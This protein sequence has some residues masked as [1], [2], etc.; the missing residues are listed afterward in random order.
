MEA[1]AAQ[2]IGKAAA[3]GASV[4][5]DCAPDGAGNAD[6]PGETFVAEA[7]HLAGKGG[8][9]RAAFDAVRESADGFGARA[10][11]EHESADAGVSDEDVA[12]AAEHEQR[13]IS[14]VSG[15]RGGCEG[16]GAADGQEE[17]GRTADAEGGVAGEPFV[18]AQF[19]EGRE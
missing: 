18:P 4:V 19:A 11:V 13:H 5:D 10:I 12:P 7:A 9:A 6:R 8:E 3:I 1:H 14:F 16:L 17:V 2:H 15:V